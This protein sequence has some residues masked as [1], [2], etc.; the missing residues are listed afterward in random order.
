MWWR[1]KIRHIA[2]SLI[3]SLVVVTSY[4]WLDVVVGGGVAF[5][6]VYYALHIRARAHAQHNIE[7]VTVRDRVFAMYDDDDDS[8]KHIYLLVNE[9]KSLFIYKCVRRNNFK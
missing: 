8:K 6:V 5:D 1:E 7:Q 3:F 9:V 2:D 4:A